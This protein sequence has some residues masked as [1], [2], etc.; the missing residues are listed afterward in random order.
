MTN[1]G[2]KIVSLVVRLRDGVSLA[3]ARTI[4][5]AAIRGESSA[6]R[7]TLSVDFD[8]VVPSASSR[9]SG[10]QSR[11]ALWLA[12]VS[13]IVLL[14]ATANVGTLLSLRVGPSPARDRG[15]RRD[16]RGPRRTS[17]D[18]S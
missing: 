8:P 13:L 1:H 9:Q 5:T 11:I 16:R 4:G 17:R 14:I 10:A 12:A 18:S 7:A 3:A 15:A 2:M 6:D